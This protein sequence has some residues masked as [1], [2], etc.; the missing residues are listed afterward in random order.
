MERNEQVQREWKRKDEIDEG[1]GIKDRVEHETGKWCATK[2]IGAPKRKYA[3]F[4]SVRQEKFGR[5][6]EPVKIAEKE[7]FFQKERREKK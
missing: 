5:I 3:A 4:K 1:K 6:E 7:C 2:R